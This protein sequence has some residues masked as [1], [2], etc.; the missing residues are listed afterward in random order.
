M[1]INSNEITIIEKIKQDLREQLE[2]VT[3]KA[4]LHNFSENVL[5]LLVLTDFNDAEV[6]TVDEAPVEATVE[7]AETVESDI[8]E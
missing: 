4:E 3:T 7:V 2:L 5:S 6:V 8:L 1:S